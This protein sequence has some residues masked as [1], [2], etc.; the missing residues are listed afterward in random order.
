MT[1]ENKIILHE[2]FV[3]SLKQILQMCNSKECEKV[4]VMREVSDHP[5]IQFQIDIDEA[6]KH[7]SPSAVNILLQIDTKT[8][9]FNSF[10][11]GRA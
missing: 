7:L 8:L 2:N 1:T 3:H 10:V 5:S 4:L 6:T 9:K 11:K